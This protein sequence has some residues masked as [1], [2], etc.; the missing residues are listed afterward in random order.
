MLVTPAA[1]AAVKKLYELK[2]CPGR[3]AVMFEPG[4]GKNLAN[5]WV[6]RVTGFFKRHGEK[7][8]THDFRVSTGTRFYNK[9][10]E[11]MAV[12]EYLGQKDVRGCFNFQHVLVALGLVRGLSGARGRA[13]VLSSSAGC[14][15]P[16]RLAVGI[17]VVTVACTERPIRS[18]K[19]NN[20]VQRAKLH[21]GLRSH[22]H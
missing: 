15:R 3:K 20:R 6:Q 14:V 21:T 11:I 17:V 18:P 12:K 9:H 7:V 19:N 5:K 2:G 1:L 8:T 22:E 4:L 16:G 10:N 13:R